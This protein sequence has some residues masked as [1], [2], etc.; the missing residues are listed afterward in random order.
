MFFCCLSFTGGLGGG[1]ER[2]ISQN[3]FRNV[4]GMDQFYF[5]IICFAKKIN[6]TE[7]RHWN[8]RLT[9][10]WILNA[11]IYKN[12]AYNAVGDRTTVNVK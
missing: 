2:K 1:G 9:N 4:G 6:G 12:I 3:K 7:N 11:C 10:G 5:S 8:C